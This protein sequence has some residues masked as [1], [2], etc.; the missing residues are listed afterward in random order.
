MNGTVHLLVS[1][2]QGP[3]ECGIGLALFRAPLEAS[4]ALAG[5]DFVWNAQGEDKAPRSVLI[6]LSGEGAE[7]FARAF[8]GIWLWRSP[9]PL[10][11]THGRANWF[12]SATVLPGTP[13]STVVD[14]ASVCFATMRAGGPGGQHQNTTD[15][16]VRATWT[17]PVTGRVF[18]A[19]A[20]DERSQHRNKAKALERLR[21]AVGA[22]EASQGQHT[23]ARVHALRAH[24]PS[25]DPCAVLQGDKGTIARWPS[26][27]PEP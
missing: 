9:S 10:R 25:G 12:L 27:A 13:A 1:S 18:T 26:Q 5:L 11:P 6:G 7:R 16:A 4:A 14:E 22:V 20:R 3:K 23:A 24:R 8:E 17:C 15:S 2:G 19:L 21:A